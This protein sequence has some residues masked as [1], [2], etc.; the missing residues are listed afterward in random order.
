MENKAALA[1]VYHMEYSAA[2]P[3]MQGVTTPCSE[4][5]ADTSLNA[6]GISS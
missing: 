5:A 3:Q 4:Y 6:Q 1:L 2:L